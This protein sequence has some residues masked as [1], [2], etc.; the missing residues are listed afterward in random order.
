MPLPCTADLD[1]RDGSGSYCAAAK[2]SV[3]NL[4]RDGVTRI[5]LSKAKK[6]TLIC[7]IGILFPE[8]CCLSG[9][10]EIVLLIKIRNIACNIHQSRLL[11]CKTS[12]VWRCGKLRSTTASTSSAS[13]VPA[14]TP[15][16]RRL[17]TSSSSTRYRNFNWSC[18][19]G[20]QVLS[21]YYFFL[22]L[23]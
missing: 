9:S 14:P 6:S 4:S 2:D 7:R 13:R 5:L 12:S 15:A 23:A 18:I 21:I 10:S 3:V 1:I 22:G 11:L 19:G 8:E 20:P 17:R 16:R